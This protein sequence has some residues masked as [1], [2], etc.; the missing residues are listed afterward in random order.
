MSRPAILFVMVVAP[1][2]AIC[3]A[4]LGLETLGSNTLGWFL[5]VL[6]IAYPAGG[7]IY[8]FIRREPFWKSTG[9]GGAVG[10]ETGDRSFWLILPG[11]LI[12]FFASPLEWMY[13]PVF[14]PRAL[15]M[16]IAG[17]GLILAAVALRIWTRAHIRGLYSGHVEVLAG[18]RLVK[19]GPYRSVRHPGYTG[20]LLMTLGVVIGYSSLIGLVAV[21]VLLLPGLAY[22]MKVEE[23]LLNQQFGEEYRVYASRSKKL[24]P[25][26]W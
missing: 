24:I 12:V 13:L 15:G 25:G 22:R 10:E 26:V 4:L 11:F 17:L 5:L 19:S 1:A 6:G 18:H 7:M 8:Y 21:P 9:G 20:F 16:Q 23:C 3:L 2:L 14:I